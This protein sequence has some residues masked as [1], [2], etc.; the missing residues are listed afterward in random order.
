MKISY[1]IT[2]CNELQEIQTLLPILLSS[3][4]QEDEIVVLVD[5]SNTLDELVEYLKNLSKT[6]DKIKVHFDI[7]NKN[8]SDWK[9]LLS[10]LCSGDYIF[11]I[12]A[13]EI[14]GVVL[15]NNL[16]FLLNQDVDIVLVP[17][18]NKVVGIQK[19]H[20]SKWG[21][22]VDEKERINW[23]DYQ[24]RIYK[25]VPNIKWQNRVH[26]TLTGFATYAAL[27]PEEFLSL[28]HTKSIEKQEKQNNF[29]NT[30]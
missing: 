7:F 4:R 17:R 24:W 2:V 1:A 22:K 6:S 21:W 20:I 12:D 29:Y 5:S 19:E 28:I 3:K 13:D 14:P 9:N 25:N 11:Q 10:S 18:V 15:I 30:L 27:P 16:P 23:P 8:F 26:E